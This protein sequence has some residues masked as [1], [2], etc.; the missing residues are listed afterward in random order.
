MPT[1]AQPNREGGRLAAAGR[2]EEDEREAFLKSKELFGEHLA[3]YKKKEVPAAQAHL[4]KMAREKEREA[5][6]EARRL[7]VRAT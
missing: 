1:L 4:D 6:N 5:A 7:K 3:N 2:T